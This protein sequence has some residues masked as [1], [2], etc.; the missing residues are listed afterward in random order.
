MFCLI[1]ALSGLYYTEIVHWCQKGKDRIIVG[2]RI[3][4]THDTTHESYYVFN[5]KTAEC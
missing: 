3:K 1:R 4:A 2:A 5:R